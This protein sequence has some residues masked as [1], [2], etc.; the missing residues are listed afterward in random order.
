[1]FIFLLFRCNELAKSIKLS[2]VLITPVY[3]AEVSIDALIA[4]LITDP[5][6]NELDVTAE[7]GPSHTLSFYVPPSNLIAHVYN[8][9]IRIRGNRNVMLIAETK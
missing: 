8:R 9:I 6:L 3:R 2:I 7:V 5:N 4:A 1:M